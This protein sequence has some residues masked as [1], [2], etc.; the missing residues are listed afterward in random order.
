[1]S[2]E[3]DHLTVIRCHYCGGIGCITCGN[4]GRLFWVNGRSYAYTQN[5]EL[6]AKA[7]LLMEKAK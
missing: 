3:E 7:Q 6:R 2:E 5:G 1:M 4:T